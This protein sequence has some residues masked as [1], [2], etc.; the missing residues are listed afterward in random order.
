M[1]LVNT[2]KADL[3][4]EFSW[5]Q[6]LELSGW[7]NDFVS[8]LINEY[9]PNFEIIDNILNL[10]SSIPLKDSNINVYLFGGTWCGD[11][12]NQMPIIIHMLNLINN[13][14]QNKVNLSIYGVSRDKLE[15]R[16]EISKFQIKFLPTLII[17]SNNTE[18]GRIIEH[19]HDTWESDILN[20]LIT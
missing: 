2:N 3:V 7:G 14:L 12:Y 1:S 4:G 6:W 16:V 9:K 10:L 13:N 18:L 17:M 19:P 15:P 20:V 8:N 5:E 11:S